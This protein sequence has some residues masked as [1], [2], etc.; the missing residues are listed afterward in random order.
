MRLELTKKTDLAFQAL[1]A[2]AEAD[3]ERV[4]GSDLAAQL[5]ISTQYLPHVVA[6][7]T[8]A[9]WVSSVSGPRGGY[10]ITRTLDNISLLDLIEAVEGPVDESR[11]LHLGPVHGSAGTCAL[12]GPWTKARQA[13]LDELATTQL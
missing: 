5:D 11:C 9:G 13:L 4:N 1:S 2:I 12:H 6:P 3:G 7:L 8:K 10:T